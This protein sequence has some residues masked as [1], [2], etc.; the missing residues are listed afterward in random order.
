MIIFDLDG[1]L[2]DIE[3]RRHFVERDHPINE[4][5]R[6]SEISLDSNVEIDPNQYFWKPDW[7]AFFEA[8]DQDKYNVPVFEVLRTLR[9]Q[10]EVEIWSGRCESVRK[11]TEK[12]IASYQP[13]LGW[14]DKIPLKM[15]P[16]RDYTPD[17]Q[18]K[19]RW[20]DEHIASGGK[21]IEFVFDDRAK[22]IKFWR[23]RGIFVFDC[24]QTGKEF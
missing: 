11:K 12:W 2:A 22:V 15:R 23:R 3:H 13:Y 7:K 20:L 4:K 9:Q 24:N 17:E 19:E 10:Y 16:I 14:A 1:T 5:K 18:L 8:C 6:L 21:P